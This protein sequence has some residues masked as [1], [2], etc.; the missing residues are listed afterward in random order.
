MKIRVRRTGVGMKYRTKLMLFFLLSVCIVILSS[1]YAYLS[2]SIIMQDTDEMLEKNMELSAAYSRLEKVQNDLELYLSTNSSDS[3][4]AFYGDS[5]ALSKNADTLLSEVS[6][7]DRGVKIKNVA[8][9]LDDYLQKAEN[10]I[11]EKRGRNISAYT[12]M[13]EETVRESD[14]ITVYME[15]IMSRDVIDSS[16]KY[17]EISARQKRLSLVNNTLIGFT[18]CF[19]IGLIVL[20]SFEVT[21]PIA[22]LAGYAGRIARGDF[23]LTIPSDRTSGEIQTLYQVFGSMVRSIRDYVN[24][25]EE[26]RRLERTLNEEKLSNLRMKNTLRESELLAL[27]S[28]VNPHFIFNTINIGAKIAML[29]GDRTTCTYLENAADIFRYNL[30]GLDTNATLREEIANVVSYMYLLQT[31]FSDLIRFDLEADRDDAELMEFAVPRMTLQPL[32][33]NAYIHGISS[34]EEG[35]TVGLKVWKRDGFARIEVSDNGRGLSQEK[36]DSI[37]NGGLPGEGPDERPA[38]T[39][40]PSGIGHTT[41]IGLDNVLRRLRIFF[42]TEDVMRIGRAD[43]I[44]RFTLVLP[45]G[46]KKEREDVPGA[47]R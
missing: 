8:N 3:L 38:G 13:Y 35:G 39:A 46:G 23:D 5:T 29:Q 27:Q 10:A 31:R 42:E 11:E 2:S 20:F 7:T 25:L 28:Q 15:E 1:L 6:Y 19:V 21:K 16:G 14:E 32:I 47:D 30:N 24:Q 34:R 33:E 45:L 40:H 36:I 22:R 17:E 44:T 4:I 18:I 26:K 41:G 43:G 9:M 37:L 12:A